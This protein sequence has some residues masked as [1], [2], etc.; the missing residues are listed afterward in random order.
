MAI[1]ATTDQTAALGQKHRATL[2]RV[3]LEDADGSLQ[4]MTSFLGHNWVKQA[5]VRADIDSPVAQAVLAFHRAHYHDSVARDLEA[6]RPNLDSGGSY[7]PLVTVGREVRVETAVCPEGTETPAPAMWQRIFTGT[8][9]KVDWAGETVRLEARDRGGELQDVWI[10]DTKTYGSSSGVAVETVMQTVLN[11]ANASYGGPALTLYTPS[12]PGWDLQE[13]AQEPQNVMELL[14]SL[15]RQIGWVVRYHWDSGT[16]ME[17][18]TFMAPDRA[19]ASP[20]LTFNPDTVIS[21]SQASIDL[22]EIRNVVSVWYLPATAT[23]DDAA[24]MG[25]RTEAAVTDSASIAKYG[26]RF[27]QIAEDGASQINT[28]TEALILAN[29]AL[30]DL[31]EPKASISAQILHDWRVQLYDLVRLGADDI[32]WS[33]NKDAGVT[34]IRHSFRVSGRGFLGTTTLGL[35]GQPAAYSKVTRGMQARPNGPNGTMAAAPGAPTFTGTA[36]PG[37]T[38]ID[39][40][41][42]AGPRT[43][44]MRQFETH[45]SPTSAF[46][47]STATLRK[48]SSERLQFLDGP[49]GETEYVQVTAVDRFGNR[50]TTPGNEIAVTHGQAG[51][52]F[53][54]PDV[55]WGG[56]FL[57]RG[58]DVNTRGAADFPPDLWHMVVG[59]WGV[60]ATTDSDSE[61]GDVSLEI[62]TSGVTIVSSY[63]PVRPNIPY[64]SELRWKGLDKVAGRNLFAKIEW[65]SDKGT[66]LSSSSIV[67]STP[68]ST[69]V[70][71]T[72]AISDTAPS[73]ARWARLSLVTSGTA[74]TS[75]VL[76]DS[77]EWEQ[78]MQRC[79]AYHDSTQSLGNSTWTQLAFN[80]ES[81]DLGNVFSSNTFTAPVDG[82]YNATARFSAA[83]ADVYIAVGIYKNGSLIAADARDTAA[84]E[85]ELDV[86]VMATVTGLQLSAGDTL[87]VYGRGDD[88]A[89][90]PTVDKDPGGNEFAVSRVV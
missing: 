6:T 28:S 35:R 68:A 46:S 25:G 44:R 63:I 43:R 50:D 73:T 81:Y 78:V 3:Y 14:G 53:L 32:H 56:Q 20:D 83:N 18:L 8:V 1:S 11:Q 87:T 13:W 84:H 29:A 21:I 60:D 48:R 62:T 70:W 37:G 41:A 75:E 90:T 33:A 4:D 38:L 47:M 45:A 51:P 19:K 2:L 12:A 66:V 82:I 7:G 36:S 80:T 65:H 15:A 86:H 31:K 39:V 61:S 30:S 34:S 22:A 85:G 71:Q 5:E 79:H 24:P 9:D 59:S 52:S 26:R 88:S 69:N 17:R 40:S 55:N 16:S 89:G 74:G 49:P 42:G 54:H 67:N 76:I 64:R 72:N 10:E 77:V 23:P 58:F 27:M 57:G